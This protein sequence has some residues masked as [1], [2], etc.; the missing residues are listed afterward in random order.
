MSVTA[1]KVLSVTSNPESSAKDLMQAILPDQ[2]MC[3]VILK[4]ANSAFFGI[5]RG[6]ASIE[7]AVVVLGYEEIRNIVIGKAFWVR[8]RNSPRQP[9]RPWDY[10]GNMPS[11]V[12]WRQKLWA[13][14][15]ESLP[16]IVQA[17]DVISH[18]HCCSDNID[19]PDVEKISKN[20][21]PDVAALWQSNNLSW[22][23]EILGP[24]L[25]ILLQH[26]ENEQGVVSIFSSE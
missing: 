2:M 13:Y 4:V 15:W 9:D 8:Y 26:R 18:M 14:I 16:L 3:S 23:P 24:C 12:A 20:F 7:R 5:P 22:Q 11:P 1:T 10:F 17:A 6:G 19:A 21:L 25:E